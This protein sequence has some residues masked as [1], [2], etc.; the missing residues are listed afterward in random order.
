[1]EENEG[2]KIRKIADE[3]N[4]LT[5]EGRNILFKYFSN[6]DSHTNEDKINKDQNKVEE[7]YSIL[8]QLLKSKYNIISPP[9]TI[10]IKIHGR[11][12]V[13]NCYQILVDFYCTYHNTKKVSKREFYLFLRLYVN[14]SKYY[15]NH[16]NVPVSMKTIVMQNKNLYGML[17]HFFPTYIENKLLHKIKDF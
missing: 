6:F 4:S 15:C 10:F 12:N 8:D 9:Y 3:I 17:D 16:I 1:M 5:K 2:F 14:I 7:F 11:S 13:G